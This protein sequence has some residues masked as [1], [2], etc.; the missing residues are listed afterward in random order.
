MNRSAAKNEFTEKFHDFVNRY[1]KSIFLGNRGGNLYTNQNAICYQQYVNVE[2]LSTYSCL[3]ERIA[4]TA[5]IDSVFNMI[6]TGG[7]QFYVYEELSYSFEVCTLE[8]SREKFGEY[9]SHQAT[10][11][12]KKTKALSTDATKAKALSSDA[13]VETIAT[14]HFHPKSKD[15]IFTDEVDEFKDIPDRFKRYVHSVV[16][17]YHSDQLSSKRTS[18]I[19]NTDTLL[20]R[21]N[22][23]STDS[24]IVSNELILSARCKRSLDEIDP[25]IV[26]KDRS[27]SPERNIIDDLFDESTA[28]ENHIDLT[29]ELDEQKETSSIQ[30]KTLFE[31]PFYIPELIL[32]RI[33]TICDLASEI[34]FPFYQKNRLPGLESLDSSTILR[35]YD[36][37]HI[38][39]TEITEADSKKLLD[40]SGPKTAWL[41]DNLIGFFMSWSL[42]FHEND[43]DN[44][45]WKVFGCPFWLWEKIRD[46]DSDYI[47][48]YFHPLLNIFNYDVLLIQINWKDTHWTFATVL[49]HSR[50][51]INIM[52]EILYFDSTKPN[53]IQFLDVQKSL[54]WFLNHEC[55]YWYNNR[56]TNPNANK[57]TSS[58]VSFTDKNFQFHVVSDC[59]SLNS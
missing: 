27:L 45:K 56:N 12:K 57:M 41:N 32:G 52:P 40:F 1:P 49:N 6:V 28:D 58:L 44:Q 37:K 39:S 53:P 4:K 47:A 55:V 22:C 9:V 46:R 42:R 29:K 14:V 16:S 50:L 31:F 5:S 59:K 11:Y 10:E 2:Y 30:N 15:D 35:L 43:K 3:K 26:E 36:N 17:K 24:E 23:D 51:Q 20:K 7:Y 48:R 21:N 34:S 38:P 25:T 33:W 13:T 19:S 18:E 54:Y 8:F